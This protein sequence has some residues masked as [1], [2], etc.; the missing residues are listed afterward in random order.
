MVCITNSKLVILMLTN[1][2]RLDCGGPSLTK[3]SKYSYGGASLP[4]KQDIT[5]EFFKAMLSCVGAM[6]LLGSNI[7]SPLLMLI[8]FILIKKKKTITNKFL[9]PHH[10]FSSPKYNS[11]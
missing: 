1:E 11:N 4:I 2:A 7:T 3:N 9:I 6:A 5:I 8:T 10:I